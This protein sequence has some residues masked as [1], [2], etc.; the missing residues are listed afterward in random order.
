[1]T[2]GVTPSG[3]PQIEDDAVTKAPSFSTVGPSISH[4][5]STM[6]MKTD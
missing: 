3:L 6:R 2:T 5:E 4:V 1:M